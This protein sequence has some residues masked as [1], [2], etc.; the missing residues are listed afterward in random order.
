MKRIA[1]AFGTVVL[2]A[3]SFVFL[4]GFAY[5]LGKPVV[6]GIRQYG[7]GSALA[8]IVCGMII[9]LLMFICFYLPRWLLNQKWKKAH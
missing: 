7:W 8:A 3:I 4:I 5:Y 6:D 2:I 9:G 1:I